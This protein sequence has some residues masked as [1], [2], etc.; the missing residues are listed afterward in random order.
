MDYRY[1]FTDLFDKKVDFDKNTQV[2]VSSI[3]IP[4]IQRPY[5]QGR[6][7]GVSTYIRN[8][9]LD[10]I[11]E[12][13]LSESGDILEL[14]FI[15]GILKPN[16]DEYKLELLD[17]QQRLTTLF[18]LYWYI[19][20]AELRMDQE[21]NT[22]V[23]L[24][25]SKFLYET[26]TSSTVFCQ[27]L[28]SYKV[29]LNGKTPKEVIRNS[30]W[31]FKS[32]DRDSTISAMLIMLDS[33][34]ERHIR[35]GR[36]D[37]FGKLQNIQFYVKSLGVFNLSEELYIKMNARGLQLSAFENFKADLTHFV[38]NKNYA[39]FQENV[40]LYKKSSINEVPFCFDFS[41]KID[42]KWVDIFW[43]NGVGNFDSSYM[44]FF[45]RFF[46]C[47][48]IIASKELVSDRDMRSDKIIKFFYTDAEEH[49]GGNE[50][51]GFKNFEILLN[52]HPEYIVTLSKVLDVLYQYDC[53]SDEKHIYKSMLPVWEKI[54]LN[55]G[56][57]FY[58]SSSKMSQ[59]RFIALGAVIEYIDAMDEFDP[60][61]F[62]RW[63]RIVWNVVENTNIDGLTPVSSLIRKFS[64]IIHFVARKINE[65]KSFFAAISAWGT[66]NSSDKE[67]RALVEEIE[68][69]RR[70]SEDPDWEDIW[71]NVESHPY[72]KGMVTFF[73]SPDMDKETYSRNSLQ[74]KEMFDVGGISEIYKKEHILIRAIVSRFNSWEEINE[75][76]I[77]ERAENNKYLKNILAT[78]DK[79]RAML[80]E[81]L[82]NKSHI[83]IISALKEQIET[84][85][86]PSL[87]ENTDE[88]WANSFDMAITR[89]RN[90][91]KMY[92]W[93]AER[94]KA[95]KACF[96][97]Y[98]F[99]GHIIFAI[100]RKWYDK[101][102]LDSERAMMAYKLYESYGFSFNDENQKA[103]YEN[104]R[105]CFGNAIW[106]YQQ[107]TNCKI[108]IGFDLYHELKIQIECRTK[109]YA[110]ELLGIFEPSVYCDNDEYQIQ[111]PNGEHGSFKHSYKNICERI[112]Y[113]FELIPE[114]EE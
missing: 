45:N 95:Q 91:I 5:A 109:K 67:S 57:D 54:T 96:R 79:V 44:A 53:K 70:I 64:A 26:R 40:P 48:Y 68:K 87:S 72:F 15:Y 69:A 29:D 9:F 51:F 19:A 100:P 10:E 56:D 97:V 107:R 7:D 28:A 43:K 50:Y 112:E 111:L 3:V 24:C 81:V 62:K 71:A 110:R 47:K 59:T 49:T 104:Y 106:I 105:D 38:L 108:W 33:I 76:Y 25:L 31:Y 6:T 84:A 102:A 80:T 103:M 74:A 89:L 36:Q 4:Q 65:N 34:H 60:I 58:C 85:F 99:D 2:Q 1:S 82:Y 21:E 63:M 30:K 90:D 52:Q 37:L 92:D 88:Y 23:R 113:I 39:L 20:N 12:C 14:N 114:L 27:E 86:Q 18:L 8:S 83:E 75:L 16:N 35:A 77:T 17:G 61:T 73:Y 13:L 93:I 78:N 55:D 66:E 94:E 11:F 101:I 41:V 22:F 42:A 46:A 32:F 98:F